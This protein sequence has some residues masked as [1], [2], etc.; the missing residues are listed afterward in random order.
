M[1]I[2]LIHGFN[3]KDGGENTVDKLAPYLI[4]AGHYVE[5]D[6]ADYG[7]YKLWMVRFRKHSA[8]C[9]IARALETADA[10][11]DHSNGANYEYMALKLLQHQ[12]R[13]FKVV[14]LSPALN[15]RTAA[16]DNVTKCTVFFTRSDF[17]V[18]LSGLL[19]THPWGQQ[20]IF[21]YKGNDQRMRNWDMTD[22]VKGHSGYFSDENIEFIAKEVLLALEA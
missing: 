2:V 12:D 3:V 16:P 22:L 18:W 10:V 4:K 9:R 6:E 14:R 5:I 17:W 7:Y 19:P 8:V 15:R 13:K 21:G 1:K 11:V 20:G